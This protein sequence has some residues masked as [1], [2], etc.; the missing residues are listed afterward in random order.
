M[1][2]TAVLSLRTSGVKWWRSYSSLRSTTLPLV[3]ASLVLAVF[4][5][6]SPHPAVTSCSSTSQP[7]P[8]LG[9]RAHLSLSAVRFPARRSHPP[10]Q[11]ARTQQDR[12]SFWAGKRYALSPLTHSSVLPHRTRYRMY[13]TVVPVHANPLPSHASTQRHPKRSYLTQSKHV[14]HILPFPRSP[15]G[16][17]TRS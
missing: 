16:V 5:P 12:L 3:L 11:L 14:G 10:S 4:A 2:A 15:R 17:G 9:P 13:I 1:S 6:T 7:C 8:L